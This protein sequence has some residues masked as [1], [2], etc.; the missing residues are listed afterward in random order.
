[1]NLTVSKVQK[2]DDALRVLARGCENSDGKFHPILRTAS[3]KLAVAYNLRAVRELLDPIDELMTKE[4]DRLADLER[5]ENP[6]AT[7]LS[8][9]RIVELSRFSVELMR[10]TVDLKVLMPIAH[11]DILFDAVQG[12][13]AIEAL[14]LLYDPALAGGPKSE[15]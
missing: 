12:Q 1:M 5:A 14:G 10:T 4:R 13:D 8:G 2:L 7:Q 3:S 6:A 15:R 11:D 9:P